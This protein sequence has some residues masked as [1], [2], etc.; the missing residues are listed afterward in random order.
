MS[1]QAKISEKTKL[2][3]D[4]IRNITHDSQIAVLE[5]AIITYRRKLRMEAVNLAFTMIKSDVNKREEFEREQS[6][7]EGTVSDGLEEE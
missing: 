5:K 2:I 6:E 7:L 4:E 3:S 1:I